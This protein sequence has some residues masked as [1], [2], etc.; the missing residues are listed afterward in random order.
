VPTFVFSSC[1]DKNKRRYDA[2]RK[3]LTRQLPKIF[4]KPG[5]DLSGAILFYKTFREVQAKKR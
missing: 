3:W 5:R 4:D 1:C 2:A